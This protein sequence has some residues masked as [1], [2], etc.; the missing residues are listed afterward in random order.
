MHSP[1]VSRLKSSSGCSFGIRS[2]H[3]PSCPVLQCL[4]G[5]GVLPTASLCPRGL[6][7]MPCPLLSAE[8]PPLSQEWLWVYNFG[9]IAEWLCGESLRKALQG[10]PVARVL[11][12]RAS[13]AE[14]LTG[15]TAPLT[16]LRNFE[17]PVQRISQLSRIPRQE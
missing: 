17:N 15:G 14:L 5:P 9:S 13:T 4:S 1:F 11:Q 6:M 7:Q 2:Q 12:H 3:F 10:V 16:G 8:C